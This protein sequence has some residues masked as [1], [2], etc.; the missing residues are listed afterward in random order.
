MKIAREL[1]TARRVVIVVC[2]ERVRCNDIESI[3]AWKA[4]ITNY[5]EPSTFCSLPQQPHPRSC[6]LLARSTF[7]FRSQRPRLAPPPLPRLFESGGAFHQ[8]RSRNL[9]YER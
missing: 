1:V 8:S 9:C 2:V 6:R 3:I 4:S 5:Q 7:A